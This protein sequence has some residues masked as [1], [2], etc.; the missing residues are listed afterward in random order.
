MWFAAL[1][2]YEENPWFQNFCVRLLQGSPEVQHLL[3]RDPFNGRAPRYV[4]AELYQYHFAEMST[5]RAEGVWWTRE[6]LGAYSPVL[7]LRD[8][9]ATPP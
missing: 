5:R 9:P 8:L 6:R 3:A 2:R 1:G 4:R 7:S